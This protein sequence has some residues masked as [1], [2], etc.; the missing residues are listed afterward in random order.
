MFLRG[1]QTSTDPV[2]RVDVSAILGLNANVK[3]QYIFFG[4]Y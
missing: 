2:S 1:A 3:V 4:V